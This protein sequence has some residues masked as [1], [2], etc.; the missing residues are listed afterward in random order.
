MSDDLAEDLRRGRHEEHAAGRVARDFHRPSPA[1]GSSA[2][3]RVELLEIARICRNVPARP[4]ETLH[5][6]LQA[7][8][9]VHLIIQIESNGH[10]ISPG[11]FDQYMIPFFETDLA[12]GRLSRDRAQELLDCLWIKFN[13]IMKL[14]DK[15][16]SIGFGGY[17]LFQNLI[18]GGQDADGRD[19]GRRARKRRR[20]HPLLGDPPGRRG[21][22]A[23]EHGA[24]Q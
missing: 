4:A 12:A 18:V 21:R 13:E 16:A 8:W 22:S 15:T 10:S 20:R 1:A 17:P 6:A 14:R 9:F 7:F 24:A 2:E 5:E 19:S 3:R 11:R 23:A